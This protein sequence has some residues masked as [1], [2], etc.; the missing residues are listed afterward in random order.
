M[1][2]IVTD[3]RRVSPGFRLPAMD[4]PTNRE[5][6]VVAAAFAGDTRSNCRNQRGRRDDEDSAGVFAGLDASRRA[7]GVSRRYR[8][9]GH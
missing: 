4:W 5:A 3:T 2:R 8:R 6:F 7:D 1:L 9:G